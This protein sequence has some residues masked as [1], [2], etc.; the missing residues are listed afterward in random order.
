MNTGPDAAPTATFAC[1]VFG[2]HVVCV[3]GA[4]TIAPGQVL[5]T[6]LLMRDLVHE[7]TEVIVVRS[8]LLPW[9]ART[10][11]ELVAPSGR[12]VHVTPHRGLRN[13]IAAFD[14]AGFVVR[15]RSVRLWPF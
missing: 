2:W 5:C 13:M 7:L 9:P 6:G 3:P 1:T 15:E 11:I 10:S 12:A 8:R 4:V 14:S